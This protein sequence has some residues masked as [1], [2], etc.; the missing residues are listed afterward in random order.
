MP[1][2]QPQSNPAGRWLAHH[3]VYR[4]T[5]YGL[6]VLSVEPDGSV[7]I[8]PFAAESHSTVFHSG[9]ITVKE[10]PTRLIFS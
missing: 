6:S 9:T 5:D 2:P 4:G 1:T 7:R 3:I 8:E 10:N